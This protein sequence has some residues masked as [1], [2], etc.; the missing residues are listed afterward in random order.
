MI[1]LF[2][3]LLMIGIFFLFL[4]NAEKKSVCANCK[5]SIMCDKNFMDDEPTRYFCKTF[6]TTC[7]WNDTCGEFEHNNKELYVE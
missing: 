2:S 5:H 6:N 3:V 1:L 4:K 7:S